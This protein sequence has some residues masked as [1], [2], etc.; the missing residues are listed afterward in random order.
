MWVVVC[1]LARGRRFPHVVQKRRPIKAMTF[2]A[3]Q[4]ELRLVELVSTSLYRGN[5]KDVLSRL[6]AGARTILHAFVT[7][8]G[9]LSCHLAKT[10]RIALNHS[11]TSD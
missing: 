5:R 4:S 10:V 11:N 3:C 9:L 7:H 8:L 2:G 1:L 6:T